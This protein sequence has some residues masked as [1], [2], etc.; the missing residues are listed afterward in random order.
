MKNIVILLFLTLLV[1]SPTLTAQ[2]YT[3][4]GGI[5]TANDT[6]VEQ[7]ELVLINTATNEK[8]IQFTGADGVFYFLNVPAGNYTLQAEKTDA[9]RAGVS[10]VDLIRLGEHLL[11]LAPISDPL[12]WL[13][14]D[15]DQS[16][17]LSVFDIQL[18]S[19]IILQMDHAF[20]QSPGWRFLRAGQQ[21]TDPDDPFS[22][23]LTGADKIS[24]AVDADRS[25]LNFTAVKLGDVNL[26]YKP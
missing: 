17:A 20:P 8:Q 15:V 5:S 21:F 13:G 18:I 3:L 10:T 6:P 26:S 24:F 23:D 25:E 9:V 16:G 2:G 22:T 7:V 19:R 4:S 14:A 12:A 1:P 11:G